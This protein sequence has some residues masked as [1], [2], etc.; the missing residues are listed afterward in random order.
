MPPRKCNAHGKEQDSDGLCSKACWPGGSGGDLSCRGCKR[1]TVQQNNQ[2]RFRVCNIGGTLYTRPLNST[3]S[4]KFGALADFCEM[5]VVAFSVD[6]KPRVFS[7][8]ARFYLL[9]RL[10]VPLV[11]YGMAV[12]VGTLLVL[13]CIFRHDVRIIMAQSPFEGFIGAVAKIVAGV[14]RRRVALVVESHGDFEV[15]VFYQRRI[16]LPA[17]Y[18]LVMRLTASFA[19]SRADLLRTV[20]GSSTE[21]LRRWDPDKTILQFPTWTDIE[22]FLQGR[23]DGESRRSHDIL[24]AGVLIP[25]KGVH[26]LINAFA[27]IAADVPEARLVIA[28]RTENKEYAAQ[29]K[30]MV[31]EARLEQQV[32]FVGEVGQPQLAALM[33]KA[34]V[35]TLPTYS[36]GLPRV[37]W[38]AMAAGLPVVASAVSGIPELIT[39]GETGFLIE[40]GDEQALA[41]RLRWV[42]EHR[43]EAAEV[44]RR[45]RVYSESFYS[46]DVYL[47]GYRNLFE[48][49]EKLRW[50]NGKHRA[51]SAT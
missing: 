20:S 10:P 49:A 50:R 7:Q 26:N 21:Q 43:E 17:L 15:A 41:E 36:E 46:T 25:R 31:K 18:R 5:F 44:G 13:W 3:M 11:R 4:K 22:P 42:L 12:T 45:A 28:G 24:F 8:H 47:R 37:V 30:A 16:P 27:S 14:F 38:E 39:E 48:V 9:P 19:I 32:R 51:S 35:F 2:P 23:D 33:R 40:P 34:A 1:V 6:K 29:V